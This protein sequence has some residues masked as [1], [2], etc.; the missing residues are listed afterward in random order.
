MYFK[1]KKHQVDNPFCSSIFLRFYCWGF[2]DQCSYTK[3]LNVDWSQIQDFILNLRLSK[4]DLF[5]QVSIKLDDISLFFTQGDSGGP[6]A[7]EK[8]E[9]SYLYGVI[10]WGDGC[11]RVNKPGVYTRM[12]NYVNWI[13]EKI[14]PRKTSWTVKY[15]NRWSR[16]L[17]S[18][19]FI[20][21]T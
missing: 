10:S 7:C 15:A 6:L 13:N 4:T 9:I 11:G 1:A 18:F 12:T 8:D 5:W 19:C 17:E 2:F 16:V 20:K 14:S 21:V 3:V